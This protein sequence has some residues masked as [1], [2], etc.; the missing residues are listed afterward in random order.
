MYL[1]ENVLALKPTKTLHNVHKIT[2]LWS[3]WVPS[4]WQSKQ[5]IK[6]IIIKKKYY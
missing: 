6:N 4:E 2:N 1:T 5:L 3:E